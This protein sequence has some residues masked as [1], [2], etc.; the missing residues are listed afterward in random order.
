MTGFGLDG[1]FAGFIR[2]NTDGFFDSGDKDL[3]VSDFSGFRRLYDRG[4][5]AIQCGIG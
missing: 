3:S 1:F 5:R 2:A 4:Q